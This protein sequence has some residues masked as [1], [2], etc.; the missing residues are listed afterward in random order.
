M[1]VASVVVVVVGVGVVTV[2]VE[3]HV[4]YQMTILI[5]P[6]QMVEIEVFQKGPSGPAKSSGRCPDIFFH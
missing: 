2:V 1:T 6:S 5:G 4:L 3:D